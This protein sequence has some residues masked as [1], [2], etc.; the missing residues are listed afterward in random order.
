MYSGP[1][2]FFWSC[3]NVFDVLV[4]K[5]E[6]IDLPTLQQTRAAKLRKGFQRANILVDKGGV[7]QI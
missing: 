2:N 3:F 7:D 1:N 4:E 6:G 5:F